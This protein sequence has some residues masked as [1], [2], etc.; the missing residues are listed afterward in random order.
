MMNKRNKKYT[1]MNAD[2]LAE[3]TKEFDE[4]FALLKGR[5]LSARDKKLHAEA[6]RRGRP[7]VG[8]GAEKVRVSIERSLL[9]E[10]DAF[11]RKHGSSRSE[12]IAR[13]L[14]AVMLAGGHS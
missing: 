9:A 2:E 3:A 6:R 13:G 12:M 10:S 4:E 11:A 8:L 1:E 5:P 14:R 7:R